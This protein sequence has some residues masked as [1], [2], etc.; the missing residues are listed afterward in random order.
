MTPIFHATPAEAA[1]YWYC[2]C[3]WRGTAYLG[4]GPTR[5]RAVLSCLGCFLRRGL[6][7][8]RP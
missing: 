7:R 8:W 2:S 4:G 3:R 5:R 6:L 1:G